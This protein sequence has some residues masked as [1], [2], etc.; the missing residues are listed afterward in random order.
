MQAHFPKLVVWHEP[1]PF[2][3]LC[4]EWV[5]HTARTLLRARGTPLGPGGTRALEV[6]KAAVRSAFKLDPTSAAWVFLQP[7][8]T[9]QLWCLLAELGAAPDGPM[10][11]TETDPKAARSPAASA[12]HP[13]ALSWLAGAGAEILFDLS[14]LGL[15]REE[16]LWP[17]AL[18]SVGNPASG[19]RVE[20]EAAARWTFSAGQ[21][22]GAHKGGAATVHWQ[23]GA[24]RCEGGH[25]AS[26]YHTVRAHA[27]LCEHDPNPLAMLEAHPGKSG[28]AI[29]LGGHTPGQWVQALRDAW[30][31]VESALP[32]LSA[33][34]EL[35]LRQIIPVGYFAEQHLS[36][37]YREAVGAVY[38]SLHPQPL[39]MMEALIHEFQH[40]KLN[41]A[42]TLDPVLH[43]AYEAKFRSP[44]RPDPRP[45]A[46]VLL[47][48]HAFVPV[49]EAYFALLRQ[50]HP[51]SRREDFL[52]RLGAICASNREACGVLRAHAEPTEHGAPLVEALYALQASQDE[53]LAGLGKT[54][55]NQE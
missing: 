54:P 29:D 8:A 45:I 39:T 33:E 5:R 4:E 7:S 30:Q 21:A 3:W 41:A 36:A 44:V 55:A 23:R 1:A 18:R 43:N 34:A 13:A 27:Q 52:G 11:P 38:S 12:P 16:V 6:L 51:V 10:G 17:F 15:L 53:R 24:A 26:P 35:G 25:V 49:A 20:T 19:I 2:A 32:G 14:R 42:M 9:S 37:S 40:N 48:A 47:A 50:G 22:V 31:L 28:N 46:G